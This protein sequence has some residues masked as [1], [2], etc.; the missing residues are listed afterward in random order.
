MVTRKRP[1]PPVAAEWKLGQRIEDLAELDQY[2]AVPFPHGHP[3]DRRTFFS[4]V[5]QV[6][7]VLCRLVASATSSLV[8]AMYGFAD[9]ELAEIIQ[10][11]LSSQKIYVS[12][13]LD[14]T[15]ASGAHEKA[16]LAKNDYPSNSIAVGRS[17]RGA[18]MHL[19]EGIIDGT[20]IITG[21]T[22]WSTSGQSLQDNE[23]TIRRSPLEAIR[24]R[25][26]IDVIHNHML[27]VMIAKDMVARPKKRA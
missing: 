4:P 24:H 21:S 25:Q 2:A 6:H 5:D 1:A 14:S 12:L 27:Q 19:K 26:R 23:L 7:A 16:I 9:E 18:I 11:H 3:T 8:L 22:N 13:T 20:D 15:Q 10:A 17:E